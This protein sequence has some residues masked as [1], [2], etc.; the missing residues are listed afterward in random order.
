MPAESGKA[1]RA[2]ADDAAAQER[3]RPDVVEGVGNTDRE[4]RV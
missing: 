3:R 2:V 1:Q 4:V